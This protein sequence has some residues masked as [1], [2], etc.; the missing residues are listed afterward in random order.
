MAEIKDMFIE[1]KQ[2]ILNNIKK[3][4]TLN[5]EQ[6]E[7]INIVFRQYTDEV[8]GE[9]FKYCD[10]KN[11]FE[12]YIC[13]IENTVCK[14]INIK[15]AKFLEIINKYAIMQDKDDSL[16]YSYVVSFVDELKTFKKSGINESNFNRD[17]KSINKKLNDIQKF[18]GR[19]IKLDLLPKHPTFIIRDFIFKCKENIYYNGNILDL[20]NDILKY[21]QCTKKTHYLKTPTPESSEIVNKN[22]LSNLATKILFGKKPNKSDEYFSDVLLKKYNLDIKNKQVALSIFTRDNSINSLLNEK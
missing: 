10:N 9:Y 11:D 3:N 2:E 18:S 4:E 20:V 6:S 22:K 19:K 15:D 5:K 13:E 14:I 12:K 1:K 17:I 16:F 8:K 21:M 7:A